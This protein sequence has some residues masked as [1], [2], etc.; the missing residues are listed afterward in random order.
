MIDEITPSPLPNGAASDL[1]PIPVLG[2]EAVAPKP[3]KKRRTKAQM[4]AARAKA[5]RKVRASKPDPIR[6]EFNR[7]QASTTTPP[8]VG[9]VAQPDEAATVT[10]HCV[11][12]AVA[13]HFIEARQRRHGLMFVDGRSNIAPPVRS[14]WRQRFVFGLRRMTGL[15]DD[16]SEPEPAGFGVALTAALIVVSVGAAIGVYRVWF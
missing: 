1:G 4:A 7:S 3:K 6:D 13:D 16:G 11:Q 8:D 15:V 5:E 2:T 12:G 9:V 14:T 10:S